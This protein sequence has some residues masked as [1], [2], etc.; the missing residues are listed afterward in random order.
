MIQQLNCT[1]ISPNKTLEEILISRSEG[2]KTIYVYNYK[3]LSYRVFKS[4][5]ELNKFW[6]GK[7]DEYKHFQTEQELDD[8]LH[9]V[10][11]L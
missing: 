6:K 9:T 4:Q 8:W 11:I 3:G 1:Y 7:K 10:D 5:E 2:E